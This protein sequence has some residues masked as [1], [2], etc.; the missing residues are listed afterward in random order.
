MLKS[1]AM[2]LM[3]D[4]DFNDEI[5]EIFVEE[6]DEVLE[7]VD[8][9][10]AIW[11]DDDNADYALKE[12][13]RGFHTL[14][15]SGRMVQAEEIGEVA[16]SIENMLNRILDKTLATSP[17]VY[18]LMIDVRTAV[19]T[20]VEA[21]KNRQAAALSGINYALLVE[22]AE[23]IL[24]GKAAPELRDVRKTEASAVT[25]PKEQSAQQLIAIDTEAQEKIKS[26][27]QEVL[28]LKRDLIAVSTQVDTLSAKLNLIPKA[29]STQEVDLQLQSFAKQLSGVERKVAKS[30]EQLSKD[31]E[32]AR[33][34]L[35]LKFEK[36][37]KNV[38]DLTGQLK[39][40]FSHEA[41]ELAVK[42]HSIAVRWSVLAATVSGLSVF[43]M[44]KLF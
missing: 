36:D 16:W 9:N 41:Q 35:S 29:T 24:A 23:A 14:K 10:F 19:P 37:L 43:V 12:I 31:T 6:I 32:D 39:A 17:A 5:I 44:V 28:E 21:F 3:P 13:R 2:S 15:G 20:L 25:K 11:K 33:H 1:E 26:L 30:S 34:K 7:L 18:E 27:S 40:D 22:R 38:A 4:D 8:T 42:A